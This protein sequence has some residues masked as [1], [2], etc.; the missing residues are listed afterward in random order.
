[1]AKSKPVIF[2]R[3]FTIYF[4]SHC[5]WL[6]FFRSLSCFPYRLG[7]VEVEVQRLLFGDFNLEN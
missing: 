4:R 7:V 6:Q 2:P 5:P 3:Y 1:M